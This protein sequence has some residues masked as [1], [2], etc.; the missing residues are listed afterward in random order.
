MTYGLSYGGGRHNVR[1]MKK[2]ESRLISVLCWLTIMASDDEFSDLTDLESDNYTE[3]H[4]K[5]KSTTKSGGKHTYRIRNSLKVPRATTYT[6]QALYGMDFCQLF[7]WK[8]GLIDGFLQSRSILV[9]S[10]LNQSINE[11]WWRITR[12]AVLIILPLFFFFRRRVAWSEAD[13]Y[14]R[15]CLSEF[16]HPARDICCQ[17]VWGWF[18]NEDLHWWKTKIDIHSQVRLIALFLF[19]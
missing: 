6:A 4:S 12:F 3:S 13:R 8:P 5:K 2:N 1:H 11:V 16:L 7:L 18:G 14:N 9:I 19:A 15:L 17:H 10:I